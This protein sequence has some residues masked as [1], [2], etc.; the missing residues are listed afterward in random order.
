MRRVL[1][2]P[3][4]IPIQYE[5]EPDELLRIP[6][7]SPCYSC[8]LFPSGGIYMKGC[9]QAEFATTNEFQVPVDVYAAIVALTGCKCARQ[10]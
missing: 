7:V 6:R 8:R 2:L 5:N 9:P 3:G 10:V 4:E 1:T